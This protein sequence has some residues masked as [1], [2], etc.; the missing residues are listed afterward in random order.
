LRER[1]LEER[2]I[3]QLVEELCDEA[4]PVDGLFG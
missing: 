4:D 2:A 3:E 1:F